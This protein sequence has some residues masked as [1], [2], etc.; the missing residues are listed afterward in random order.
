ME[1]LTSRR[2][3][4][5][6]LK[7]SCTNALCK[8]E[9]KILDPMSSEGKSLNTRSSSVMAVVVVGVKRV[10]WFPATR[11]KLEDL[12]AQLKEAEGKVIKG[13]LH[14]D[15]IDLLQVCKKC[16]YGSDV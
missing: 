9:G 1:D 12:Q 11:P 2:G 6:T 8:R 10:T 14:D 15:T 5:L 4:V 7:I 3:L 13:I 16:N